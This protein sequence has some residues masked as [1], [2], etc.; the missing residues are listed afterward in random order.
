MPRLPSAADVQQISP[1]VTADP[2]IA[3]KKIPVQAFESPVGVAAE[4]LAPAIEKYAQVARLQENRRD[5]ID[6]SDKINRYNLESDELL[7]KFNAENDLSRE[8]VMAGYGAALA[9][10]R[11]ELLQEHAGSNDSRASLTLRLQDV[12]SAAIGRAA[13]ISAKIGTDKVKTR[14]GDALSSIATRVSTNPAP[15]NI[16]RELTNFDAQF[17]DLK[18]AFDPTEEESLRRAGREHIALSALGPLIVR[19]RVETA[20]SLL[21]EGGLSSLLSEK[22]QRDVRRQ[23]ETVRFNR[24]EKRKELSEREKRAQQLIGRGFSREFAED[25][26][27]KDVNVVGPDK[28]GDYFTV[29]TATGVKRKVGGEDRKSIIEIVSPEL[30]QEPTQPT[31]DIPPERTLEEDVL[32]GTGP[33][34]KIQAGI[35]NV[36]GPV[37]EGA[38][39]KDTTD[40]RQQVRIFSQVAKTGLINNPKFPVAEQEIVSNLLPDPDEFF[41]DPD[42]AASNLRELRGYFVKSKAAKEKESKKEKISAER[43]ANLADQ[44]SVTDELLSLMEKPK[45]K[46]GGA[47]RRKQVGKPPVLNTQEQ[48][49][50]LKK[51]DKFIWQGAL[52]EKE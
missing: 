51:G 33:F 32:K 34:A 23:I 38:V 16:D 24:D 45:T 17:N 22:G 7:R 48:V 41:R 19:G 26:A 40:A 43:R 10:R 50:A 49:D 15:Q 52:L 39:F 3:D 35:S 9:K 5:T 18:G 1:K 2:G 28:F 13:G 47:E 46:E 29:N 27:A 44:I 30:P 12:E 11:Q 36:F 20:E 4:E 42:T 25:V 21:I 31:T 37:I 14:L 8:D 6:R